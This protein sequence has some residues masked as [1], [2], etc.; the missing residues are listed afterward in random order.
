MNIETRE[1]LFA[2]MEQI[3]AEREAARPIVEKLVASGEPVD[4]IEIPQGWRTAGMVMEL[5]DFAF[6]RLENDPLQSLAFAQL[7]LTIAGNL[8]DDLYPSTLRAFVEGRA[9]KEVGYANRY[10]DAFDV[11]IRAFTR[12]E[13]AFA[14][15]SALS[16]EEAGARFA[17][18]CVL[19]IA[20]RYKESAEL[21]GS[22][23][24]VFRD[25]GNAL[26]VTKCDVLDAMLD[27]FSGEIDAA[28]QK[29][30][31][32]LSVLKNLDD[33][34]TLAT[35]Y[36]GLGVVYRTLG[37]TDD[38]IIAH[39]RAREIFV[40][41][42]M[43][44]EVGRCDWGLGIVLLESGNAAKALP[45]LNRI[46]ADFIR[47]HMPERAGEVGLCIVDG[48]V[49]LGQIDR[50]RALTEQV[51]KEFVNAN[52]SRFAI[53]ALAYLR[54]LLQTTDDP[55]AAIRHVR[56]YVE[57]LKTEPARLFLPLDEEK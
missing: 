24:S 1:G 5:C 16:D 34:H 18:A 27:Y 32:A 35:V 13:A 54:D 57:K 8:G 50:A 28:R 31:A 33:L 51:L 46:R 39:K 20:G 11:G 43:P 45:V 4:D 17:G 10:R 55:A 2:V 23:I 12:S 3:A 6:S 44:S 26:G 7:A 56:L 42:E 37:R 48:F 40:A 14:N 9:W 49:A 21:N 41:L 25:F 38:A 36:N 30:E 52:L 47:R 19:F 15:D 53:T 29:F 22:A